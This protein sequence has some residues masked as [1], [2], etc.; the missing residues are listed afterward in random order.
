MKL[1]Q[2]QILNQHSLQQEVFLNV[3]RNL[4]NSSKVNFTNA[5][6]KQK[7]LYTL[8]YALTGQKEYDLDGVVFK[9]KDEFIDYVYKVYKTSFDELT[10]LCKKIMPRRQLDVKLESWLAALG[11]YDEVINF[12]RIMSNEEE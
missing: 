10:K 12:N 8:T 6:N 11:H 7:T 1:I 3:I 4:E 9:S 5:R 2:F